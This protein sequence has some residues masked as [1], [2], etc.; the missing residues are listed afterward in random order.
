MLSKFVLVAD[1]SVK[2]RVVNKL[3]MAKF[4]R[5]TPGKCY[6]IFIMNLCVFEDVVS[7]DSLRRRVRRTLKEATTVGQSYLC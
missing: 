4:I 7:S 1:S 2:N 3:K 6:F 5:S